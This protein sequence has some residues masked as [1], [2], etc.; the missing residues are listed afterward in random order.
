MTKNRLV[1]AC[2]GM[3]E[4]AAVV[5]P[6][7]LMAVQRRL[8]DE[9]G[10]L[11]QVAQLQQVAV[12]AEVGVVVVDLAAQELDAVQG[13]FTAAFILLCTFH[14]LLIAAAMRLPRSV[15]G[16]T[17]QTLVIVPIALESVSE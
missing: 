5:Q 3:G 8:H 1:V 7:A 16:G 12:D 11:H 4:V 15:E 17:K 13:A 9:L 6:A 14:G 10:A 2:E